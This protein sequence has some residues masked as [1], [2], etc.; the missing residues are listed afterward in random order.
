MVK[1]PGFFLGIHDNP[2]RPVSKPLEHRVPH[3][4]VRR[5]DAKRARPF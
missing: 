3:S 2:P 5:Q 4:A 1:R